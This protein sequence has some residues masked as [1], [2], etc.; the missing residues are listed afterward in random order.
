[1]FQAPN[2]VELLIGAAREGSQEALGQLLEHCRP[3]LKAK[4]RH[5]MDYALSRKFGELE[6]IQEALAAAVQDFPMFRGSSEEQIKA[7]LDRILAHTALDMSKRYHAQK[8]DVAREVP[9]SPPMAENLEGRQSKAEKENRKR[10]RAQMRALSRSLA[11]LPA[12]YRRVIRLHWQE[13][14][15]FPEV[16]DVMHRSVPAV[17]KLWSRAFQLWSKEAHAAYRRR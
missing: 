14:K 5:Y 2:N 4:V 11:S 16:A 15:P 12:A 17:R 3:F 6:I 10:Q 9:L 1:M 13:K 7:W 8:R